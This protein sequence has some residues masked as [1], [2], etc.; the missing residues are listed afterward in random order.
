MSNMSSS[1]ISIRWHSRAGQGAVTAAAALAEILV[2]EGKYVKTVPEFGAEKRGAGVLVHTRVAQENFTLL[3]PVRWPKVVALIDPTLISSGENSYEDIGDVCDEN[4]I[5]LINTAQ[6]KTHFHNFF[7]G[8]IF[9]LNANQIALD[10]IGRIIPNVPMLGAVVR[11]IDMIAQDVFIKKLEKYLSTSF[12]ARIVTGNLR[13]FERGFN[14]MREDKFETKSFKKREN[15]KKSIDWNKLP[16]AGVIAGGSNS[17][18]YKTTNWTS[19]VVKWKAK[20]CIH[21]LKCWAVCPDSCIQSKDGKMTGV[22]EEMCK[23]CGFCVKEC[24]TNPKSLWIEEKSLE[25]I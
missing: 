19:Q 11:L 23:A 6:A 18:E 24:P 2:S 5:L 12:S 8:K 21:C 3:E 15:K 17:S 20:T 13:A 1:S 22:N 4:S 9:H 16:L 14:E 7:K 25:E 10:E